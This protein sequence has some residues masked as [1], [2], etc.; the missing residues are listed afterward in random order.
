MFLVACGGDDDD[1]PTGGATGQPSTTGGGATQ[2][3]TG[4]TTQA[5][6]GGT[7]DTSGLLSEREDT[8]SQA[9]SGGIF[10][11]Y[12]GP[13][14]R[15]IDPHTI[16]GIGSH[17][18]TTPQYSTLLKFKAGF[19]ATPPPSTISGD[20]AESFELRPDG[21]QLTLKL[22]SNHRFDP[23][24]PTNGRPMT[25]EDVKWS[26]DRTSAVS[27]TAGD[28]VYA[29]AQAGPVDAV[30]VPDSQT[31]VF[32][33]AYPYGPITELLSFWFLYI[34]PVEAESQFDPK[35]EARG[36]GPWRL[37]SWNSDVE[38]I[39]TKNTDWYV[40]GQ[41][42]LD[43]LHRFVLPEYSSALAQF[44]TQGIW[45]M[46]VEAEDVLRLK[47]DHP[48]L[49]MLQEVKGGS[50]GQFNLHFGIGREDAQLKDVRM[51]RAMSMM[52]DRELF[53]ERFENLDRFRAAGLPIETFWDSQLA[54]QCLNWVDPRENTA[55]GEHQQYFM[56]NL[57]EAKKLVAAAGW[58]DN[59]EIEHRF[60][61][62]GSTFPAHAEVLSGMFQAGGLKTK[63]M[64]LTQPEW[65]EFKFSKGTGYQGLLGNTANSFND[66]AF[67]STKYTPSGRDSVSQTPLPGITDAIGAARSEIDPER[68]GEMIKQIQLDLAAL[69]PDISAVSTQP[70]LS[71]TLR[72]PWLKN[73]GI[74]SAQG[75]NALASTARENT[76][77]WYDKALHD[78]LGG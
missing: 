29:K 25:S 5:P 55:L 1:A 37:E 75:F 22:R 49:V 60:L 19:G 2:A 66:D 57:E 52:Y 7:Q 35:A 20:A 71:F 48:D 14:E 61:N 8:T 54:S 40:D 3:P 4:G 23:R 68:R 70:A 53:L 18:D 24:P 76:L 63:L 13:L 32:D 58:D 39:Y 16:G 74:W 30:S 26:Y 67:L 6:T 33:L 62:V 15:H 51:R 41:P 65:L 56:F 42:F 31:V 34:L 77:Y 12:R 47:K 11:E 9:K 45:N 46:A 21:L 38:M 64:P 69:M 36:S 43:G 44:E 50:P 59:T 27:A 78:Q 10:R 72:W 17:S 73:H 28:M